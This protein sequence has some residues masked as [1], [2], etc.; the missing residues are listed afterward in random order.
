MKTIID[1]FE[2]PCISADKVNYLNNE[3]TFTIS[4]PNCLLHMIR[5]CTSEVCG[6]KL[7][8]LDTEK[9]KNS[10]TPS[11]LQSFSSS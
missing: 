11:F 4:R 6:C 5:T 8:C 9:G 2:Q 1:T 10:L 7:Y 3:D